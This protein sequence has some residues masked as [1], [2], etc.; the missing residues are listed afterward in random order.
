MYRIPCLYRNRPCTRSYSTRHFFAGPQALPL[1]APSPS[2]SHKL[3]FPRCGYHH[4]HWRSHRQIH[5]LKAA[6]ASHSCARCKEIRNDHLHALSEL[7]LPLKPAARYSPVPSAYRLCQE[8]LLFFSLLYSL[9]PGLYS[10]IHLPLQA[11][12]LFYC[13]SFI[14]AFCRTGS[15]VA[16]FCPHALPDF[17]QVPL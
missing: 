11:L 4:P 14:R 7:L 6:R 13:P 3:L 1:Q 5:I 17:E 12:N 16:S 15:A 9:N 8:I 10:R 2:G